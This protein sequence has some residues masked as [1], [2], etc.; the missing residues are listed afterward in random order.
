VAALTDSTGAVT[1]R[2]RYD[3]YGKQT[4]TNSSGT[5][6]ARSSVN[7]NRGFTGYIADQ[8]SGLLHARARQ[9]SPTQGRFVGRD[10]LGHIDGVSLYEAYFVPQGLDPTGN[11]CE[12]NC[13][14]S[15]QRGYRSCMARCAQQFDPEYNIWS[16]SRMIEYV[17]GE[18]TDGPFSLNFAVGQGRMISTSMPVGVSGKA[19]GRKRKCCA[20]DGTQ[21]RFVDGYIGVGGR[22]TAGLFVGVPFLVSQIESHNNFPPCPPA[23]QSCPVERFNSPGASVT[24]AADFGLVVAWHTTITVLFPIGAAIVG[25]A[26]GSMNAPAVST[27]VDVGLQ[28]GAA[29]WLQV[30]ATARFTAMVP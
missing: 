7:W 26:R 18:A 24:F 17:K 29:I 23:G 22:V 16:I 2:Y 1:E 4:I 12:F 28:G 14:Q 15:W 3:A 27:T 13:G 10:A 5:V 21:K 20:S 11:N 25:S 19:Y 30:D 8:E 6:L 9:F